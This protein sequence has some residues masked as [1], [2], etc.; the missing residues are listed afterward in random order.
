MLYVCTIDISLRIGVSIRVQIFQRYT[1]YVV[2]T[3]R[4][5]LEYYSGS[6]KNKQKKKKLYSKK[7]KFYV[8]YL[9][10]VTDC[11]GVFRCSILKGFSSKALRLL[12]G[13]VV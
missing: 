8:M 11:Y 2:Y 9:R 1:W 6:M 13:N 5:K 10:K 4:A 7:E 3:Q 12:P